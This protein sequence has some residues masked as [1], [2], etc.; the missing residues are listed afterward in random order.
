M[1][2]GI[3]VLVL[4]TTGCTLFS[5]RALPPPTPPLRVL[6][7]Q[8]TLDAPV[9]SP[10][11]LYS[12]REDPPPESEAPLL[13]QLIDEVEVKGQHILTEQLANQPGFTVI[14]F[15]AARRM[16]TNV[17]LSHIT[18]DPVQL[19]TLGIEAQADVVVSGHIL[20]YG[21]VRW[22][23]WVPGLALS[24]LTETLIVGAATGFNPVIMAA[25]AGSELLTDVPFWWGGAY[26]AGWAL[27]PVQVQI[28]ARRVMDCEQEVWQEKTLVMLVPWKTLADYP[29]E[30]RRRKEV[31]L[32]VNL[33]QAL[34]ELAQAAGREFRLQPCD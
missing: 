18:L 16:R 8:I 27:R 3:T 24:M 33:T 6:V 9:T 26:F 12:F 13:R 22:Q 29:P 34:T 25:T 19:R 5:S 28:E 11:D 21:V 23:Y 31:Q 7:A 10:T 2:L 15:S 20:D 30:E 32:E 1:K 4:L 17:A 14:P